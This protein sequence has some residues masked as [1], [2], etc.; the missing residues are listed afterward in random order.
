MQEL[1][2]YGDGE[3]SGEPVDVQLTRV[4]SL[5]L[6]EDLVAL[7]GRELHDLVLDRGAVARAAA[8]DRA[9][10]QRRLLEVALN[11]LLQFLAGPRDPAWHLARPL[12]PLVD[13]EAIL[14]AVAVLPL[15]L[16][17][18]HRAPIDA[19]GRACLE[20]RYCKSNS[21]NVLRH[22][23][24][25]LI[26][27]AA[28]RDLCISAEMNAAAEESTGRDDD[29]PGREAASV[30][31]LDAGH[32][33]SALVEEQVCDHA[34]H[35]LEGRELLEQR[36]HGAAV[37]RPIALRAWR[38]DCRA[39][40]AIQHSE[41]DRRAIRGATHET[42]EGVDLA[43]NGTLR[44]TADGGITGHLPDRFEIGGQQ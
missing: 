3:G 36:A 18:I 21:F 41:L 32:P 27:C 26:A 12:D 29:G 4:E 8:A 2:L 42:A 1:E 17:P 22:I 11:D 34:L 5:G 35:E 16:A 38:P 13:R 40:G 44:N 24:G 10:I 7:G 23:D 9:A 39:L 28:R 20:T 25:W 33:R 37:E 15:D 14:V 43:D 30:S 6:E 31:R 19:W